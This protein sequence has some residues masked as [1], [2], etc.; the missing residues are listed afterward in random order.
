MVAALWAEGELW[1]WDCGGR[2]YDI[3]HGDGSGSLVDRR[4]V[5]ED[6]WGVEA[7]PLFGFFVRFEVGMAC[8]IVVGHGVVGL[9]ME[10]AVW[11]ATEVRVFQGMGAGL[12]AVG[13]GTGGEDRVIA[14]AY[15]ALIEEG[16]K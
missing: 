4:G 12:G 3:I 9:A 10:G 2:Q 6:L 1:W 14:L 5:E 16:G 15:K 7:K 8:L 11:L 13:S